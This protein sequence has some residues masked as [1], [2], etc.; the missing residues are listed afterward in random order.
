MRSPGEWLH[1][2][3]TFVLDTLPPGPATANSA[4]SDGKLAARS[5]DEAS[6]EASWWRPLA[7]DRF[8][9]YTGDGLHGGL[10]ELVVRGD[11]LVGHMFTSSDALDAHPSVPR[12][13]AR[14][15][16]CGAD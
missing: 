14:R 9:L 1:P 3:W 7:T 5:S 10:T 2:T 15:V 16:P 8:Q 6:G 11:S 13:S 4:G 12:V